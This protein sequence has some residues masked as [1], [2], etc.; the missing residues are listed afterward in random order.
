MAGNDNYYKRFFD[1][2]FDTTLDK[3]LVTA[4]DTLEQIILFP[5]VSMI[6]CFESGWRIFPLC[7]HTLH[8]I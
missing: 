7:M 8:K 1:M 5:F 3:T 4:F 2:T 6:T